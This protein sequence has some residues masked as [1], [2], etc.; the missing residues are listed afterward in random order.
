MP[1]KEVNQATFQVDG[2]QVAVAAQII[3]WY[4]PH[5]T[6]SEELNRALNSPL[7]RG[8]ILCYVYDMS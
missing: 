2:E 5:E 1:G 3:H 7:R 4:G 8:G 6:H